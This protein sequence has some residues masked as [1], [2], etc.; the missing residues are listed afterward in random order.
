MIVIDNT[1]G[2]GIDVRG[3]IYYALEILGYELC[4]IGEKR[5]FGDHFIQ[6]APEP[7][8]RRFHAD[9]SNY[10]TLDH[11]GT[12][13]W[14]LC[15]GTF[16]YE[17]PDFFLGPETGHWDALSRLYDRAAAFA[18]RC[19]EIVARH[20]PTA[21]VVWGGM[22]LEPRVM[23]AVGR[24][25]GLPVFATEFSF[26]KA[27][28][29]L[30]PA[31]QIGNGFS[32]G[33]TWPEASATPLSDA[34]RGA[35]RT[36]IAQNDTGKDRRQPSS[37]LSEETLRFVEAGATAPLLLLCQCAVDTVITFDNPHY[38]N[39][40][41]AYRATVDACEAL[42][43]PLIV[44]AHPGD[45]PV[46]KDAI[47]ALCEG[48]EGIRYVGGE[49]D[50]NV[51]RLMDACRA[52]V[53]INSQSGLEMMAKGKPVL[54]VGR[55]FYAPLPACRT[56]DA[57]D[58]LRRAI[59]DLASGPAVTE[60]E[61]DVTER[62]LHHLLFDLLV[63]VS[64]SATRTA[65]QIRDRL[66]AA[67]PD[68]PSPSAGPDADGTPERLRVAIVHPS[69]SW[70]GS[71]YYLQALAEG[72]MAGGHEVVILCEGS[73]TPVDNGVRWRVLH[74]DGQ[75]LR[76]DV[77]AFIDDFA[78][79]VVLQA[80]VRT[81]P[82]RAAL[83]V[84]LVHKPLVV[85]QAEDDEFEPFR[86]YY[87]KPDPTLLDAFD[88]PTV[89]QD[90]GG[91]FV[92]ALDG[93]NLFRAIVEPDHDR[94]VE[95]VF[96][97]V[98][99][100]AAD[101]H[102]A[103]W[104]PMRDRLQ[105]R[106]AKPCDLLPPVVDL[107]AF[108][109][110]PDVGAL[111]AELLAGL[112][113]PNDAVVYFVN[114]TIYPYSSEFAIFTEALSRLQDHASQ[115]IALLVCGTATVE[116]GATDRLP[117][118]RALGR[119]GDQAYNDFT[120][121]A[122]V[123]CAPGVPDTFN[124][125]RMPSRLVKAMAFSRPIFTFKTGFGETLE[126]DLD[127]FFT[128]TDDVAEWTDVLRRTLDPARRETAARR[129]RAIV[130]EHFSA[131]LV[132]AALAE[133]WRAHIATKAAGAGAAGFVSRGALLS[134][135]AGIYR[136]HLPMADRG[137]PSLKP[138]WGRLGR[139]RAY[140]HGV[141]LVLGFGNQAGNGDGIVLSNRVLGL[142]LAPGRRGRTVEF[143]L[144][145]AVPSDIRAYDA[146]GRLDVAH[147]RTGPDRTTIRVDTARSDLLL[148]IPSLESAETAETAGADLVLR[149]IRADGLIGDGIAIER[150]A[151][152]LPAPQDANP[153]ARAVRA[154]VPTA[155]RVA[156]KDVLAL[157]SARDNARRKAERL[158]SQ[159]KDERKRHA[160][161]RDA[162]SAAHEDAARKAASGLRRR[163]AKAE[164]RAQEA[165]RHLERIERS[166]SW[167]ATAWLR[168]IGARLAPRR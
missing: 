165:K 162:L 152:V 143:D 34:Q 46:Y 39:A 86:K 148:T 103:I 72:L 62:Y 95:P 75:L 166:R 78:P 30:D 20:A 91:A 109:A 135:L 164:G 153:P 134:R 88:A 159:L 2:P 15:K 54:A 163:L 168:R 87:P 118:F 116:D 21:F 157:M 68:V 56:L 155:P 51:Y 100:H 14:D 17:A 150:A 111:R 3:E 77:R 79:N 128:H 154:A 151:E 6:Y 13:L 63:D 18:E 125:Y 138:G 145:G 112:G 4:E 69:P 70:G 136:T 8:P 25:H 44:K 149:D 43:I 7:G 82:I 106:F 137:K 59:G 93:D 90:G 107:D 41:A 47:R 84:A 115:P 22:F 123:V 127:G 101:R 126:D 108:P 28:I 156:D 33:R 110:R 167:R 97:S 71:G 37:P 10:R 80:G 31:G 76:R 147:E 53:T 158:R 55:A 140:R 121:I 142:S 67:M 73:C 146:D 133:R 160:A 52:G 32:V 131:P 117:Y 58:A 36:W 83:E 129:G 161:D 42:G 64:T 124:R 102:C 81:K 119:L 45:R 12:N 66:A 35:V 60:G 40:I 16:G 96:R 11:D 120:Q 1:V 132:A 38:P 99:Y 50:E 113:I 130:Q 89:T 24:R 49:S 104:T 29:H 23:A 144:E 105:G 98:M 26:D 74:F 65:A 57:P 139:F 94:W 85:V 61:Q 114:G 9:A 122:D 5:A 19:E 141:Q 92:R 27:R 48:R